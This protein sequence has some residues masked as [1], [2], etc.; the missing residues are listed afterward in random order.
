MA[1]EEFNTEMTIDQ[2]ASLANDNFDQVVVINKAELGT[3]FIAWAGAPNVQQLFGGQIIL[4]ETP[5][6]LQELSD[7]INS[8]LPGSTVD[9]PPAQTGLG[10]TG[11]CCALIQTTQKYE[12]DTVYKA[13][14]SLIG[15]VPNLTVDHVD[16][17]NKVN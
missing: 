7:A 14:I 6:A 5:E 11:P 12:A 17:I 3:K 1:N 15:T 10:K 16:R 4:S 13:L 2:A 9:C 8:V